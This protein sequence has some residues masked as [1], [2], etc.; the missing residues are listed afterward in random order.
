MM[1]AVKLR[2]GTSL[3]LILIFFFVTFFTSVHNVIAAE[4]YFPLPSQMLSVSD[5]VSYPVVKG[6][7]LDPDDPLKL[8]FIIDTADKDEVSRDEAS[9]LVQYFLAAVTVPQADLWVNL[10]PYEKDRII[11]EELGSTEL[12]SGLLSQDYVLKQLSSSLTDPATELGKAYWSI[13]NRKSKLEKGSDLI[14]NF[15]S[16][17]STERDALSKVWIVPETSEVYENNNQVFITRATLDIKAES[18]QMEVLLPAIKK[19]VNEGENFAPLRQAH[20]SIILGLWFKQRLKESIY[21]ELIDRNKVSGIDTADRKI[22]EQVFNSYIASFKQGVYNTTAK[23]SENGHLIKKAYFSGGYN[24]AD[25]SVAVKEDMDKTAKALFVSDFGSSAV[26][27]LVLLNNAVNSSALEFIKKIIYSVNMSI[28]LINYTTLIDGYMDNKVDLFYSIPYFETVSKYPYLILGLQAVLLSFQ[29]FPLLKQVMT[30]KD[31]GFNNISTDRPIPGRSTPVVWKKK[32]LP[33]ERRLEMERSLYSPDP[34]MRRR[35]ADRLTSYATVDAKRRKIYS[36][37][38]YLGKDE[39]ALMLLGENALWALVSQL[40][41]G[42]NVAGV[43]K[44]LLERFPGKYNF[45]KA[46]KA[47]EDMKKDNSGGRAI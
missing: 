29:L 8:E 42:E 7:R 16:P 10:S 24:A 28:M 13:E 21:G 20:H 33:P 40:M 11:T 17:V 12:G 19:E 22:K 44:M 25:A 30:E 39:K 3:L 9:R 31:N 43:I 5:S 6:L 34:E 15:D 41:R 1:S 26:S 37:F 14:S 35:A 27:A 38:F 36:G 23:T 45:T 46:L 47:I 4:P 32:F 18:S 2:Q